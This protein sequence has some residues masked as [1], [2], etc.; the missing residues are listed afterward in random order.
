[1][2]SSVRGFLSRHRRKFI[3]TGVVVGGS[4]LVFKYAKKK[5]LDF[6]ER[7]AREFIERTQRIQYFESQERNCNQ[8]ILGISTDLCNEILK[9]LNHEELLE[10]LRKNPENKIELWEELK[11]IAFTRLAVLIYATSMLNITLRVQM[12]VIGGYVYK[13][14]MQE[15]NK[16]TDDIRE[17]YLSSIRYFLGDGLVNLVQLIK[18]KVKAILKTQSLTSR[19]SLSDLEQLFWSIQMSINSDASD[20][21]SKLATYVMPSQLGNSGEI[22]D[23]MY[24][25][26]LDLLESDDVS[27]ICSNNICR[28]FSIAVDGIAECMAD[29]VK[30]ALQGQPGTVTDETPKF[31]VNKIE[32]ALAKI[33]PILNGLTAKGVDSS[34]KPQNFVT[35]VVTFFLVSEKCKMLGANVYEVFSV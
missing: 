30:T 14:T 21:N 22:L 3:V 8:V 4:V 28:G 34:K 19:L 6:Q 33:I 7:Q 1:M 31:N 5:L 27:T 12:N 13:D 23:K 10:R 11:I 16:L 26:T 15:D 9:L 2:L 18:T 20:P 25:E 24:S 17:A 35:S 32:L 29:S